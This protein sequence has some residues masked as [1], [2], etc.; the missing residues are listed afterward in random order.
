VPPFN[1][2]LTMQCV[3]MDDVRFATFTAFTACGAKGNVRNR[4]LV[5]YLLHGAESFLRS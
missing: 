2:E 4:I 3:A 1:F 5:N